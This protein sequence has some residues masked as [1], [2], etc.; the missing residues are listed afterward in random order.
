MSARQLRST[1]C[2]GG[3]PWPPRAPC[4]AHS[5]PQRDPSGTGQ[6]ALNNAREAARRVDRRHPGLGTEHRHALVVQENV[7]LQLEHLASYPF[8]G[9]AVDQ[10]RL[11][12]SGWGYDMASGR[13]QSLETS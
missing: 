8:V 9:R 11:R 13:I 7:R 4:G 2:Q 3:H 1:R 12:L 10:G 5:W 6:Q